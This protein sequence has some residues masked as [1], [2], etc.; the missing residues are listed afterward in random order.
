VKRLVNITLKLR[1][2]KGLIVQYV[3]VQSTI[4]FQQNGYMNVVLERTMSHPK[5][6]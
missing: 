6:G 2:K 1:D 5:K 3:N 4:G